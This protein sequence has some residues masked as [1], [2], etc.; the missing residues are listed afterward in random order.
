V[1]ALDAVP[2][3]AA[4]ME[5]VA[6]ALDGVAALIGDDHDH[7]R[8]RHQIIAANTELH[9][10]E[11]AKL[12]TWSR[13]LADGLRQR[14]ADEPAA[15]LAAEVGVAVFRVAFD[16]WADGPGDRPLTDVLRESFALLP[17]V[18]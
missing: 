11:L 15:S 5:A 12:A 13:A 16:R 18:H 14:G 7:S 1:A 17:T 8:R 2:A 10:R 6:A 3:S 9:E 4:P